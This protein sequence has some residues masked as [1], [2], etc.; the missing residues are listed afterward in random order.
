L[1]EE[2]Q[3][4]KINESNEIAERFL[5][6]LKRPTALNGEQIWKLFKGDGSG[7]EISIDFI[8]EFCSRKQISLDMDTFNEIFLANNEKAL[9]NMKNTRKDNSIFIELADKLKKNSV[10]A[11]LDSYKYD[12]ELDAVKCESYYKTSKTF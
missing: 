3:T 7:A 12:F 4:Q 2:K 6:K 5:T 11:T 8:Q 1:T 9:K 10:R